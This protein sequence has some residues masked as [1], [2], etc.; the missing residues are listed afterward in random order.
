MQHAAPHIETLNTEGKQRLAAWNNAVW[1]DTV[2]RAH[3][4]PGE[5]HASCWV[6][7]HDVPPFHSNMT[8]LLGKAGVAAQREQIAR[9]NTARA[10]R[11]GLKDGF[12]CLDLADDG[13]EILFEAV[14]LWRDADTQTP[15]QPGETLVWSTVTST[16]EL[17][18]WEAAWRG[19]E[20]HAGDALPPRQFPVLLLDEPGVTFFAG[21]APDGHIAAVGIANRT[22]PVVGLSNVFACDETQGPWWPG[23]VRAVTELHPGLPLVG[24]ERDPDLTRAQSTAFKPIAPL[25]VW[26]KSDKTH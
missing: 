2:C 19:H 23:L 10:G 24:Y 9:I 1:C 4:V 5:M 26:Y 21:R 18:A 12:C 13:F 6:N 22:G 15:T 7:P 25:R 14:W 3:G 11:F 20:V 17:D 16:N 8:T